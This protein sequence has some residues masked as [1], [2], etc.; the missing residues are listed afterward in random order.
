MVLTV[1]PCHQLSSLVLLVSV[2]MLIGTF[3]TT[4]L[5]IHSILIYYLDFPRGL[6]EQRT[7]QAASWLVAAVLGVSQPKKELLSFTRSH[8]RFC[9][10]N[11][12]YPARVVSGSLDNA[13][14]KTLFWFSCLILAQQTLPCLDVNFASGWDGWLAQFHSIVSK[15][16][17]L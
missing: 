16:E 13:K 9:L 3:T 17:S 14:F 5:K 8:Q 4:L 12:R 15:L 1:Q 7:A 10:G 2:V 6:Q 11:P